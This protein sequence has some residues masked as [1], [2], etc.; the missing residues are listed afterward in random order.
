M[1]ASF[2]KILFFLC[3]VFSFNSVFQLSA[4]V[5]SVAKNYKNFAAINS[6]SAAFQTTHY[7]PT[8]IANLPHKINETSALL[9]LNGHLWTLNDS[10]NQPE[11]YCIDST[12]GS[13]LRTVVISN[14]VNTDWESMAQDDSNV[15]IGDFGNNAGDRKDLQILKIKKNELLNPANDSVKAGYIYFSYPDQINFARA[16]NKNNFDCEAFF[17][18]NDSLH[19]FSKNWSDLNSKHYVLPVDTGHY[20][21][22]LTE[23]F[24]VDGLI[25]DAS[26]NAKGNIVLLGYKN[27]SGRRYT[28]F[29]WLLKSDERSEFFAGNKRK[30]KLGSA[31]HLGQTEG[32][33][34]LDDNTGWLSSESIL[35]GWLLRP[36]KLFR[37]NFRS[38]F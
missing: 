12:N 35:A 2:R 4:Q 28:C 22:R 24:N 36:A 16:L 19:L 13:V 38:Y 23:R 9:F 5:N 3:F 30:L 8:F 17:C 29:A 1:F 34:L 27:S 32:I 37:F 10:R 15:Y 6:D 31:L 14:A 26:I 25:T 18:H 33:V 7:K 11:I 21:A 20:I